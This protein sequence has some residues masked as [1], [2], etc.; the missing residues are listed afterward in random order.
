MGDT[1]MRERHDVKNTTAWTQSLN[2][3]VLVLAVLGVIVALTGCTRREYREIDLDDRIDAAELVRM[4]PDRDSD[5]LRFGFDLRGC[6]SE[7]A[8]QYLPLLKYL[9][10]ATGLRFDLRFTPE[11]ST[12]VEML[13][14]GE[15][16]FAAIGAGSY[17]QARGRYGAIP[18]VRG[19]SAEGRSEYQSVIVVAP[20][21][22]IRTIEDLRGKRFAF[23]S[24]S[25]TQGHLIPRI[26]LAEHGILLDDLA[27]HHYTGSDQDCANAVV[28][29]RFDAG[30]MQD[31]L[32][33]RL[34]GEGLLRIIHTSEFY[35]SSGIVAN[36]DVPPDV[37]Q[38]VKQALLDFTP[39][40][41]DADGLYHWDRTEMANGFGEVRDEDYAELR[42]WSIRFGLLDAPARRDPQ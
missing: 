35:P 30:G 25:S 8:R 12:T 4:E 27:R 32:G 16:D 41:A 11:G 2:R 9:E 7:D 5:A 38:K 23:G 3:F 19:L 18:L 1:D 6:P 17:L 10:E 39:T 31:I 13:G 33:R 28:A 26:V 29:G 22:P 21:S 15:F 24:V 14:T 34:A 36:R 42:E 40:G 20:D 37:I